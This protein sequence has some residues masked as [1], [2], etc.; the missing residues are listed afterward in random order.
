M[1]GAKAFRSRAPASTAWR[2]ARCRLVFAQELDVRCRGVV[3][4]WSGFPRLDRGCSQGGLAPLWALHGKATKEAYALGLTT[5]LVFFPGILY[6][7]FEV[8]AFHLLDFGLLAVYLAQYIALWA[9]AVNW[10][11][12]HTGLAVPLVAPPMWIAFEYAR[13]H[14]GFLSFPWMLFGH[15]QHG[16]HVLLQLTSLTGVYGLSFL[17]VPSNATSRPR[18]SRDRMDPWRLGRDAGV[19]R[20]RTWRR[21]RV[22]CCWDPSSDTVDRPRR[23]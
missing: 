8:P 9:L 14:F 17:L 16:E 22:P 21:P 5:G 23:R 15:S 1:V 2:S 19:A 12:R 13:A 4:G 7:I 10:I 6:W 20:R 18:S 11:C 3:R